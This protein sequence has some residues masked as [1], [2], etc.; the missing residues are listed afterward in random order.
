MLQTRWSAE[1][2]SQVRLEFKL[3]LAL[4][5]EIRRAGV[6]LMRTP[7]VRLAEP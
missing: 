6:V 2:W 1:A 7:A 4:R 3:A 5:N